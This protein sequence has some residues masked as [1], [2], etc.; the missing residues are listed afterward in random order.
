MNFNMLLYTASL[1]PS[2]V[3]NRLA[4]HEQLRQHEMFAQ[5]ILDVAEN[6]RYNLTYIDS[7]V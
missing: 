4:K 1:F 5:P 2:N 7:N 3:K 6:F